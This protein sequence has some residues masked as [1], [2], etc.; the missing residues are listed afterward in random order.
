MRTAWDAYGCYGFCACVLLS[1]F[2]RPLCFAGT[3]AKQSGRV[4][5]AVGFVRRAVGVTRVSA[6]ATWPFWAVA[7]CK[8]RTADLRRQTLCGRED[9]RAACEAQ[10]RRGTSVGGRWL[11]ANTSQNTFVLQNIFSAPT[12]KKLLQHISGVPPST[13]PKSP[14]PG[15]L[16][17]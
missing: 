9:T 11:G 17:P 1:A 5:V 14:L 6:T 16:T 3:P 15:L 7:R 12:E 13:L 8:R 4:A 2:E 10:T